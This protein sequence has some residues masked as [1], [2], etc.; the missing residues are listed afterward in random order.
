MKPYYKR[1][2]VIGDLVTIAPEFRYDFDIHQRQYIGIIVETLEENNEYV[3]HWTSS[4]T[5]RYDID[6]PNQYRGLWNGAH[7]IK[8]EDYTDSIKSQRCPE[9]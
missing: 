9:A 3:V 2:Y 5:N 1:D 8:I 4:P 6:N 7:L